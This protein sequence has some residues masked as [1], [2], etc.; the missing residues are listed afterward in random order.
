MVACFNCG[1]SPI[2]S[3]ME[4]CPNCRAPAHMS[5]DF[6]TH[7][8]ATNTAEHVLAGDDRSRDPPAVPY[9]PDGIAAETALYVLGDDKKNPLVVHVVHPLYNTILMEVGE[10]TTED[11]NGTGV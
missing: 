4:F 7:Q 5:F 3:S 11:P 1:F 6:A 10:P 2:T 8:I 9:N